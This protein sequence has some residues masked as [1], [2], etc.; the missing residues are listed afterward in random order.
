MGDSTKEADV[1]DKRYG[2]FRLY[3]GASCNSCL[4][5]QEEK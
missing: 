4:P 3:G 1:V 5:G 2:P